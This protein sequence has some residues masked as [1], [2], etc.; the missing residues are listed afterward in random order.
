MAHLQSLFFEGEVLGDP[1]LKEQ[2]GMALREVDAGGYP[3]IPGSLLDLPVVLVSS[4]KV[5]TIGSG[6]VSAWVWM[7]VLVC[8]QVPERLHPTLLHT[9][10]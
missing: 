5:R 3:L 1:E 4:L 7:H 9:C 2:L 8:I 10:R 6:N